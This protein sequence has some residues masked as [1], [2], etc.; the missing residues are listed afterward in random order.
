M[1]AFLPLPSSRLQNVTNFDNKNQVASYSAQCCPGENIVYN[2]I[3]DIV[4][5]LLGIVENFCNTSLLIEVMNV[6]LGA[7]VCTQPLFL[8]ICLSV[9]SS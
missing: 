9:G 6:H 4:L 2:I 8:Q 7:L 5:I 1:S 3:I